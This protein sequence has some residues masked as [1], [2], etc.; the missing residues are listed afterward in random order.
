VG[1]NGL[2]SIAVGSGGSGYTSVPQVVIIGDGENAQAT[3]N[4]SGGVVT[5][6]DVRNPGQGYT[7]ALVAIRGGNNAANATALLMPFGLSGTALESY[8]NRVWFTNGAAAAAF[9]PKNRTIFSIS[10]SPVNFDPT[11][12][13]GA[14][15][16]N[17]S[18]L[19]VGYH[20]LRQ[21][22][23]FLYLIGDSSLNSISGV[24]QSTTTT[25]TAPNT[26]STTVTT[27]N[28]Q[29]ADPQ[30]GS[31]WPSSV[32]QF[33]RNIV[34]ANPMGVHISLGG[35]VT[36]I[37]EP[38][39]GF[40]ASVGSQTGLTGIFSLTANFSAA[41]AQIFGRYVY[42][43]LLPVVDQYTG[44]QVNKLLM[45][46]DVQGRRWW[47]SQQDV[48]LIFIAAQE[49]NSILTAYGTDGTSIYPL[50]QRPSTGFTKTVR[51]KLWATP[52]YFTTKTSLH[53]LGIVEF[54]IADEPLTFSADNENSLNAASPTS[55]IAFAPPAAPGLEIFGPQPIGQAGRLTGITLTTTASDV[56]ILSLMIAGQVYSINV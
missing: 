7:V 36:K 55:S 14:F 45:T 15:P 6:I 20:G 39:D 33:R 46:D 41:V 17:D 50:F 38:L 34:L 35:E 56:A 11:L 22:N 52:G 1:S 53:A 18:F 25:G 51:S 48:P 29:N 43:I 54:N 10:G 42:M 31:A 40:Y 12:G 23:G 4:I 21:S 28:N 2:A 32:Q 44:Q 16:S 30:I 47:T 5:S 8:V 24:Q 9:P 26:V 37:S 3:A 19:R 49:F 13:G 27:F